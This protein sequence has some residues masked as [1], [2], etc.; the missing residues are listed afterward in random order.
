MEGKNSKILKSYLVSRVL[1]ESLKKIKSEENKKI[2]IHIYVKYLLIEHKLFL[3][4]IM[5]LFYKTEKKYCQ[6][7]FYNKNPVVA[8]SKFGQF[9]GPPLAGGPGRDQKD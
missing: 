9:A 7:F 2:E 8:P 1:A 6:R 5:N 4:K 3:S